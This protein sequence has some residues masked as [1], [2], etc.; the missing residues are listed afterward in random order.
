MALKAAALK[1]QAANAFRDVGD[2]YRPGD[3]S[4]TK[5]K[6]S[7]YE[8]CPKVVTNTFERA[9]WVQTSGDDW[10]VGWFTVGEIRKIFS[11]DSGVRLGD[12]QM[13]NHFPNHLELTHKALMAKNIKRFMRDTQNSDSGADAAATGLGEYTYK[14]GYIP[15]TYNLPADY[16]IFQEEFKRCPGAWWIMKPV[17]GLQGKGIFLVTNADPRCRSET[18][19]A[20]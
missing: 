6:F 20:H 14:D 7:T 4:K 12:Q 2:R 1:I 13:V 17:N 3:A 11:P 15:M 9:G 18:L 8:G 19:F 16:N 5:V 10:N